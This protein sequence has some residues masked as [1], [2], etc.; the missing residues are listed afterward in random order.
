MAA[1]RKTKGE[2]KLLVE[3]FDPVE[4]PIHYNSHPSGVECI[5]VTEHMSLNVGS[6]MKY[7]WRAG[8]KGFEIRDLE[9]ARWYVDREI[10]RLS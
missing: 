4:R 3:E 6:A 1:K 10:K 9:K 2:V 8:L 5:T 7:L